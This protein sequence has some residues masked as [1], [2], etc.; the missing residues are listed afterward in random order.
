MVELGQT[1][2]IHYVARAVGG[3]DDGAVVDTTDVDVALETG[4][5]DGHRNFEPLTFEVGAGTV[6]SGIDAAVREM[7]SNEERT[8]VLSPEEAYGP[9]RE[10]LVVEFPREEI[11]RRSDVDAAIGELVTTDAGESGWITEVTEEAV[12]VDFNHEFAGE[13]LEFEIRVLDVRA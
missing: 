3:E 5:Y 6:L 9:H 7:D 13:P 12:T 1:V 8:V 2:V 11:E 4:V 10:D